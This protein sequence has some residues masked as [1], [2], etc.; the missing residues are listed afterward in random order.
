MG[1]VY[2]EVADDDSLDFGTGDIT[3][4]CWLKYDF[5]NTGSSY[6]VALGLGGNYVS[7][8]NIATRN[9]DKLYFLVNN[10]EIKSNSIQTNNAWVNVVGVRESGVI[11]MYVDSVLQT[12]TL[13][14]SATITNSLTKYVG[15]DSTDNRHYQNLIDEPLI[16]NRA[17]TLKEIQQNYKIGLKEH[18]VGSAFSDDFSSDF[19]F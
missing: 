13:T 14:S 10:I 7:S 9:D 8:A 6:N 5:L 18:K 1:V 17:L 2:G 16:Y 11:S 4:S 12:Q 19:G 15:R 3:M